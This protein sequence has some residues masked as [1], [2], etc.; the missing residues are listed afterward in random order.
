MSKIIHMDIYGKF[1]LSNRIRSMA[2]HYALAVMNKYELFY[3]WQYNLS[4]PGGFED[5][6]TSN[7]VFPANNN[8]FLQRKM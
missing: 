7:L 1:G 3:T 8:T 5:I 2:G 6:F 4:C